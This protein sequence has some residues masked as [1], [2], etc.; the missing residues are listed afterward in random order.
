MTLANTKAPS[1]TSIGV[2]TCMQGAGQRVD[3][4]LWGTG[5]RLPAIASANQSF[6][7]SCR[8]KRHAPPPDNS[9]APTLDGVGISS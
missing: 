1:N 9:Q 5:V 6:I 8:Y 4:N 2:A 7:V 3:H